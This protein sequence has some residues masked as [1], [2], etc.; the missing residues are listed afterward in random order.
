MV[1][2]LATHR[3]RIGAK[4]GRGEISS[5]HLEHF[6]MKCHQLL[7]RKPALVSAVEDGQVPKSF[8]EIQP[9]ML[10]VGF[11][12]SI[13]DYGVFVQFPSGLSGLAPKAVSALHLQGSFRPLGP[14]GKQEYFNPVEVGFAWL[15]EGR[16]P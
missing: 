6:L 3:L 8:S 15:G 16:R 12:K 5:V 4:G 1:V 2:V 13:K 10:L 9:G 7:C 11:V 14:V